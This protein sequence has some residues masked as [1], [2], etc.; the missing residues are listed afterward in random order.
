MASLGATN[1]ACVASALVRSVAET[2]LR[3]RRPFP[4]FD[5]DDDDASRDASP[6]ARNSDAYSNG[7]SSSSSSSSVDLDAGDSLAD[8]IGTIFLRGPR[9]DDGARRNPSEEEDDEDDDATM[10]AFVVVARAVIIIDWLVGWL[11]R[12][13]V[14]Q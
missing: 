1:A 2:P 8:G 11:T 13:R 6:D 3:C 12:A 5:D 10:N 14:V 7:S 4:P 9:R